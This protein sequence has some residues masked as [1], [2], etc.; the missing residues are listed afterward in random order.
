MDKIL[1]KDAPKAI[2]EL[3]Q[4]SENQAYNLRNNNN[5]L[6]LSKPS[7]NAMKRSFSYEA[8]KIWNTAITSKKYLPYYNRV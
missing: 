8:A 2:M 7:T 5:M 4:I 6:M 1:N 3:Y